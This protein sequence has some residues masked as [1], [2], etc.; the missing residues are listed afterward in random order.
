MPRPEEKASM[1]PRLPQEHTGPSGWTVTCPNLAG[2]AA[3]TEQQAV[4]HDDAAADAGADGEIEQV[5]VAL[6]RA[7]MP[8]TQRSQVGI[9]AHKNRGSKR[10]ANSATQ[11]QAVPFG[12]VGAR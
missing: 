9:I 3:P 4:L 8:F 10:T 7:K 11:Q 1:C 6:A 12:D 5:V 2:Q